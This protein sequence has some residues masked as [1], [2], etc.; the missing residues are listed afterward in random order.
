[1]YYIIAMCVCVTAWIFTDF[2]QSLLEEREA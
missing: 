1:M 2:A